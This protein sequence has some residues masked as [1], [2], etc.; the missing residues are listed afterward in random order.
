MR[1]TTVSFP[2]SSSY[3]SQSKPLLP[4]I[5]WLYDLATVT[6]YFSSSGKEAEMATVSIGRHP[7]LPSRK[8]WTKNPAHMQISNPDMFDI[9][10]ANRHRIQSITVI[11]HRHHP[12][13]HHSTL[14][15]SFAL[16][17]SSPVRTPTPPPTSAPQNEPST[18]HQSPYVVSSTVSRTSESMRLQG[19]GPSTRRIRI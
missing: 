16:R 14:P 8:A 2:P 9:S 1:A 13:P 6:L 7:R 4:P 18:T 15:A 19:K 17:P 11:I 10:A 12:T 3:Y 5:V